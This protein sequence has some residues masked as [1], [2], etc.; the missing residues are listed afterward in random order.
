[1]KAKC[2]MVQGTASSVGKSLI[3]AGL[4]RFFKQMGF[5]VAPFKSQN[6]A[7]NSFITCEGKEMGRAQV[8]QAEAAGIEP[9]GMMNPVLIKPS[10]DLQAQVIIHGEVYGNMS[11]VEYDHFK[12]RL[13][14]MIKEEYRK[15]EDKYDIIV[16]EGAGSPAEINLRENDIVNM[17][18]AELADA[19]VILVGDIDK[20]GV[21]ASLAGTM[22]LLTEN[23]KVRVQG[24]VIN[25][26][27]GDFEILK[28]GLKMLEDIIKIPVLGVLPHIHHR[29]DDEDGFL[30]ERLSH[31]SANEENSL[32]IVVIKFPHMS[33]YTDF[34]VLDSLEGV[35]VRYIHKSSEIGRPDLIIL[36]GS[37]NTM[38][39]LLSI[40]I[41]G[42]EASIK[43]LNCQGC[44]VL[45]IC[46][47]YQMLGLEIS[48]PYSTENEVLKVDGM[49]LLNIKTV[50]QPKKIT[51]QVQARIMDD[52]DL[53][54]GLKGSVIE[55][56]EI[57]MGITEYLEGSTPFIKIE[58]VLGEAS[59]KVDGTRNME[60]SVMGTYVHGIFDNMEFTKGFINNLRIKKG[61]APVNQQPLNYRELKELEYDKLAKLLRENLDMKKICEIVGIC[62]DFEALLQK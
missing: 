19:P 59:E 13:K 55:G 10:S 56:Y 27:R 37:K 49:G 15:L 29:I 9:S 40:R 23:E 50:F 16:I 26:F 7:L 62:G 34:N 4:C 44:Y 6:M 30:D 54:K 24:V 48:D 57:H 11:A 3:V 17:G 36:P 45:G 39:D 60:G 31:G 47:G 42:V 8:V 35:K 38:G 14:E 21:F 52:T 22:L 43:E 20:G 5:S 32:D 2:I 53:M 18:M 41:S 51:T 12:P 1:M 25:K 58:K 33:N 28:P 61:L 46:G